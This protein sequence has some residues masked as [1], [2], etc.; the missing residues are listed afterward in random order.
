MHTHVRTRTHTHTFIY[1]YPYIHTEL[2]WHAA[3]MFISMH[4]WCAYAQI[5]K[6]IIHMYMYFFHIYT[7]HIYLCVL[8]VTTYTTRIHVCM[9]SITIRW[10]CLFVVAPWIKPNYWKHGDVVVPSP[11]CW[12][13]GWCSC[14]ASGALRYRMGKSNN[15]FGTPWAGRR[16]CHRQA[17]PV[18]WRWRPLCW[19]L[20]GDDSWSMDRLI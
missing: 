6:C 10:L 16:P 7:L 17:L 11:W 12:L 15:C 3:C 4:V 9:F 1:I 13:C 14:D 8:Y 18:P 19:Q 20:G 5:K 2:Y